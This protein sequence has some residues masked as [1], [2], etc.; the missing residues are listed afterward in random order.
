VERSVWHAPL[1]TGYPDGPSQAFGAD[2][3]KF[4][5]RH[6]LPALANRLTDAQLDDWLTRFARQETARLARTMQA[7]LLIRAGVTMVAV[8][9]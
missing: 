6:R 5:R 7:F 9:S 3:P 8:T 1:P 2:T 4:A